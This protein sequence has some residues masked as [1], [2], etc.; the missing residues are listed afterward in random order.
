MW[1]KRKK[2][3]HIFHYSHIFQREEVMWYSRASGGADNDINISIQQWQLGG[4]QCF[5]RV[6]DNSEAQPTGDNYRV[7]PTGGD[8]SKAG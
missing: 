7:W 6:D 5:D 4:W 2:S 8:E 3:E 1:E